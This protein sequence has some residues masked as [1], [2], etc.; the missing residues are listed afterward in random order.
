VDE[1]RAALILIGKH[2]LPSKATVGHLDVLALLQS[3]IPLD[4]P[5]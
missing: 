2:Q 4:L 1:V 3:G 5:H